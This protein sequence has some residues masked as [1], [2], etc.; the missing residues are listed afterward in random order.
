L[1]PKVSAACNSSSN[2]W[3][4]CMKLSLTTICHGAS[5]PTLHS[6]GF[7]AKLSQHI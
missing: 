7:E 6:R 3:W 1:F 5:K 2:K 4:N